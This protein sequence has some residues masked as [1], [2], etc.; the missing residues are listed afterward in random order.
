MN[1]EEFC[2]FWNPVSPAGVQILL[3]LVISSGWGRKETE[4]WY[5]ELAL[6]PLPLCILLPG[7]LPTTGVQQQG[8]CVCMAANVCSSVIWLVWNSAFQ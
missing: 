8:V 4:S 2:G 3:L 7:P 6:Q 5:P 1:S